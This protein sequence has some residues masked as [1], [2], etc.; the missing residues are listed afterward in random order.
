MTREIEEAIKVL[1]RKIKR[2]HPCDEP[3]YE[4]A[5]KA[6]EFVNNMHQ[7]RTDYNDYK[8]SQDERIKGENE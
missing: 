1:K 8:I 2:A 7:L 4:M 3:A 5:I 6:L